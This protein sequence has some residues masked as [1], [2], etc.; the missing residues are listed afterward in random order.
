MVSRN[1]GD[2]FFDNILFTDANGP[3]IIPTEVPF[4]LWTWF[5]LVALLGFVGVTLN[6]PGIKNRHC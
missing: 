3:T 5:L 4:P 6:H 1:A 2:A